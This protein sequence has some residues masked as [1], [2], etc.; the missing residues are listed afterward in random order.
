MESS[1]DDDMS[2]TIEERERRAESS[3]SAGTTTQCTS[4]VRPASDVLK[5]EGSGLSKSL[6]SGVGLGGLLADNRDPSGGLGLHGV[7][8]GACS[9]LELLHAPLNVPGKHLLHNSGGAAAMNDH[10]PAHLDSSTPPLA[11][12]TV[13]SSTPLKNST[14]PSDIHPATTNAMSASAAIEHRRRIRQGLSTPP[15]GGITD[16]T[17]AASDANTA[18][19][20]VSPTRENFSARRVRMA[21]IRNRCERL[22]SSNP[23]L[24]TPKQATSSQPVT[25]PGSSSPSKPSTSAAEPSC[26]IIPTTS[27]APHL[28]PQQRERLHMRIALGACK[29]QCTCKF[30]V[31]CA[32]HAGM[33]PHESRVEARRRRHAA[34]PASGGVWDI[35]RA[36]SLLLWKD[37]VL[38][39]QVLAVLLYL[40]HLQ[41]NLFSWMQENSHTLHSP[42]SYLCCLATLK[43]AAS[44]VCRR[45]VRVW[46]FLS[47]G[48]RG[49]ST[50]AQQQVDGL[51]L[52]KEQ[53]VLE[54]KAAC[55][56]TV[57]ALSA[58]AAAKVAER[59]ESLAE[60]WYVAADC[61]SGRDLHTTFKVA[62]ALLVTAMLS[63]LRVSVLML[64][65]VTTIALFI[66][67]IA[68]IKLSEE[69][70]LR[71][72]SVVEVLT[73][74][75]AATRFR[76]L[77]MLF[78]AFVLH[79]CTGTVTQIMLGFV[80]AM[81]GL[82]YLQHRQLHR[83][84][85]TSSIVSIDPAARPEVLQ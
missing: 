22:R 21:A 70:E 3:I 42:V 60:V 41:W 65:Y 28:A 54:H 40:I 49:I 14:D 16:A 31:R 27:A 84:A 32:L 43:L 80:A 81:V 53:S 82:V 35:S 69:M 34:V 5:E 74:Y 17:E 71:K 75:W 46:Q 6:S 4:K 19:R 20:D 64:A 13:T 30:A 66:V 78:G 25:D 15:N 72:T 12:A 85:S 47:H 50:I 11:T 24:D 83:F 52:A 2:D 79:M 7:T 45:L 39:G 73:S 29:C 56:A 58:A 1:S 44:F 67:P 33:D 68:Y 38:S 18:P 8:L 62:V 55:T 51:H 48:P 76:A 10:A 26:S 37:P 9:S 57:R 23:A 77:S 59:A 61:L 36:R 63:E